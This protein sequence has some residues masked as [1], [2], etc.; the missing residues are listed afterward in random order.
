MKLWQR[1]WPLTNAGWTTFG[2]GGRKPAAKPLYCRIRLSENTEFPTRNSFL[3]WIWPRH[4]F[5]KPED[6]LSL[7]SLLFPDRIHGRLGL[8]YLSFSVRISYYSSLSS[9]YRSYL[10]PILQ[11]NIP[12]T[13]SKTCSSDVVVH[14]L[15]F[16]RRDTML[17][18]PLWRRACMI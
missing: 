13:W 8:L 5:S 11:P 10:P 18:R 17:K 7:L 15:S 9:N 16:F 14:N 1:N 3:S 12:Y 4:N 2:N 6:W